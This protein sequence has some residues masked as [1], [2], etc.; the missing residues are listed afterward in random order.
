MTKISIIGWIISSLGSVF[1]I[2]GYFI[3]GHPPLIA[4][5][6]YT[7]AWIAEFLPNIESEIGMVFCI[8]G[9]VAMYWPTRSPK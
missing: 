7:P 4:W 6:T 2:F 8:G 1:W 5:Q 3:T 9:M